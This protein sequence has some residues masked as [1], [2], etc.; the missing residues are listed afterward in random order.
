MHAQNKHEWIEHK[1]SMAKTPSPKITY[2]ATFEGCSFI[3]PVQGINRGP[4][5]K[6]MNPL[7]S[8]L[9]VLKP[10][11]ILNPELEKLKISHFEMGHLGFQRTV[12]INPIHIE[13]KIF[14]CET[15]ALYPRKSHTYGLLETLTDSLFLLRLLQFSIF[16]TLSQ[17]YL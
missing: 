8:K 4:D 1:Y 11:Q 7:A 16:D 5:S 17:E 15:A 6:K 3:A 14:S 2:M 13:H 9:L 12:K 10:K